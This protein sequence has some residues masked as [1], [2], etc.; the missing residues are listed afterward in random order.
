M[1]LNISFPANGSQKLFD[2]EDERKLHIFL[3]KR[4][5][6]LPKPPSQYPERERKREKESDLYI[7]RTIANRVWG[8]LDGQ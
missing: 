4:V 2:I 1:Q 8:K 7:S 6:F 5:R 3:E